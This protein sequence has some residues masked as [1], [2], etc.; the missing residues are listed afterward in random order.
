VPTKD[1][2]KL[3]ARW[4]FANARWP[5]RADPGLPPACRGLDPALF[6]ADMVTFRD[7]GPSPPC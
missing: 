1:E 4:L 2:R 6:E 5:W 7:P 3:G